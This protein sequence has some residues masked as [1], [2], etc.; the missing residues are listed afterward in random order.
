[1][2]TFRKGCSILDTIKDL[3]DSWEEVKISTLKRVWK[4]LI[5][6][7]MDDFEQLKASTEEVAAY[8]M[9]TAK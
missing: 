7:L 1:M 5:S 6:T 4:K 3:N 8:L 9:E 2:K